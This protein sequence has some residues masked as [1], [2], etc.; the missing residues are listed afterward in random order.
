MV[1]VCMVAAL[2]NTI[3]AKRDDMILNQG[4]TGVRAQLDPSDWTQAAFCCG[5]AGSWL[6]D[7]EANMVVH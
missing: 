3:V 4:V 6:F 2:Y 1:V 7:D 5:A